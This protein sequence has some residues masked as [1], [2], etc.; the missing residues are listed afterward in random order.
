[1]GK[2]S[3]ISTYLA[4]SIQFSEDMGIGWRQEIT[5][6][7][8]KLGLEVLDPC[9]LEPEKMK[10]FRPNRLP[11]FTYNLH[12]EKVQIKTWHDLAETN[13]KRLYKRFQ[14][15]MRAVIHFDLDIVEQET[16]FVICLWTESTGRGA[17]T[18]SELCAAFRKNI[19]VYC[20]ATC[21]MPAWA[22]GCCTEIFL[23]LEDLKKFLLEEYGED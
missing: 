20:I 23:N 7:L 16:D 19:P 6:F 18:H 3:K 14:R 9:K 8:E 11:P 15:M 21:R 13:D 10:N 2:R 22:K 1:M 5:P 17:G 4:G 12:G